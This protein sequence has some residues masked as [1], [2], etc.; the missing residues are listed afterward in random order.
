M[1]LELITLSADELS[2]FTP[3]GYS[4]LI[5]ICDINS[6]LPSL[7]NGFQQALA[8]EYN[9]SGRGKVVTEEL[10][11][12][13]RVELQVHL[14]NNGTQFVVC[15]P[16]KTRARGIVNAIAES[17]QQETLYSTDDLHRPSY[18][19]MLAELRCLPENLVDTY[20][21]A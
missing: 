14:R 5:Y 21:K 2:S 4:T 9:L 8:V 10:T 19:K 15:S 18:S 12:D 11:C 1:N 17:L 16:A 6:E 20:Q 3:S 13:I 7:P